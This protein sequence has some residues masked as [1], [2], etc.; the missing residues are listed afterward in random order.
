MLLVRDGDIISP[1]IEFSEPLKNQATDFIAAIS[2]HRPPVSDAV[3]G[4]QVVETL[5]AIDASIRER[6]RAVEVAK[7]KVASR[8]S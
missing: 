7:C 8:S 6:G 5:R 4:T 1:K 3:T 2:Q